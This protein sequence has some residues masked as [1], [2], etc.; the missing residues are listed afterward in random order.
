MSEDTN[1]RKEQRPSEH[2][3]SLGQTVITNTA[4]AM[5]S[6]LDIA[7]ARGRHRRGDWGEV[8]REDWQAN[9]HALKQGERLLSVY[10]SAEGTK[11]WV[12]TGWDHS[13]TTV[14]L[15]ADY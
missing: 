15:P 5:L 11:F 9:D 3:F 4:L 1:D 10:H 2:K 13:I 6:A 7:G 12:I 14:L 8:G